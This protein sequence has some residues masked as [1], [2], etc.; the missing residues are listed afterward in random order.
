[1]NQVN[2]TIYRPDSLMT[3]QAT[4]LVVDESPDNPTLMSS[5]LRNNCWVVIANSS[6]RVLKIS[7]SP[8]DPSRHQDAHESV[9]TGH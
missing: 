1:M 3:D 2:S 4:K 7:S 6:S 5:L 9:P 8:P